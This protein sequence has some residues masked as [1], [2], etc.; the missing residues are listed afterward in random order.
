[1]STLDLSDQ[2]A[3]GFPIGNCPWL[4]IRLPEDI[5]E[6][7]WHIINHNKILHAD[8]SKSLAGNI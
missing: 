6:Y 8:A 4:D 3:N 5:I 2:Q 1:M 7:L